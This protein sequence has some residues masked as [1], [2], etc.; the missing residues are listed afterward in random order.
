[1]TNT[2]STYWSVDGKSLQTYAYNIETL[3]GGRLGVPTFRGGN[4]KIP[5]RE[6]EMWA[7][8][9]VDSRTMTLRFWV[10]GSSPDGTVSREMPIQRMFHSNLRELQGIFWNYDRLMTMTKRFWVPSEQLH[11][12]GEDIETLPSSGMHSLYQADAQIEWLG[13]LD[14]A[15]VMGGSIGVVEAEINLPDPFFYSRPLHKRMYLGDNK[16][17]NP[18]DQASRKVYMEIYGAFS[19]LKITNTSTDPLTGNTYKS[20][21]WYNGNILPSQKLV[22]SIDN[23]RARLYNIETNEYE[24]VS[25]RV[26]HSGD[27]YWTRV[28]KGENNFKVEAQSSGGHIEFSYEPAWW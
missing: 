2:T 12:A 27:S 5:Y 24:P 1:M 20:S 11:R 9:V 23:F 4:S 25:G 14:P 8:K 3:G 16:I 7:P 13:G 18:G 19:G 6:G 26:N 15:S 22:I 17:F 10:R 28:Y 21:L